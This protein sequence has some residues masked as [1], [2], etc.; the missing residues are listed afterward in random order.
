MERNRHFERLASCLF[1]VIILIAQYFIISKFWCLFADYS[2]ASFNQFIR[3][4]H[5]SGFDPIT[6]DVITRWHEGYDI[7]RHPLLAAM[8][9]PLYLLNQALWA[10]TGCNCVQLICGVV[11]TFCGFWSVMFVYRTM[12]E[13]MH[14]GHWHALVLSLFFLG[15]AYVIV[16]IIV[17]D[18]F[19]LSMFCLT[20]TVYLSARKIN[21]RQYFS[22]LETALLFG[23]TAGITLTNG[24]MV[25]FAVLVVNGRRFW[26]WRFLLKGVVAPMVV[27]VVAV[28]SQQCLSTELREKDGGLVAQ[29]MKWTKESTKK[30]QVVHENFFGESIQLHRKNVLGDVLRD[31]PVI[32]EYNWAVQKYLVYLLEVLLVVG[33]LLALI[34]SRLG[35]ILSGVLVFNLL[36]HIVFGFGINEV[37]IMTA[38]WAFV[39]PL[40]LANILT[41]GNRYVRWAMLL[42]VIAFTIY[43]YLYHGYLLHRYLTWPLVK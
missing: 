16:S 6:Y 38:H 3:N 43:L 20:L 34:K 26:D 15:F 42:M 7:L 39:V 23:I 1:L 30:M 27:L 11:L 18:H 41:L 24:A 21:R 5:M 8:M 2:D 28:G 4:F 22:A 32:V 17:P 40:A 25:L 14:L 33:L 29:Q 36:L 9:Y 37:Y 19:C 10:I 35:L 13:E 12:A 31:R